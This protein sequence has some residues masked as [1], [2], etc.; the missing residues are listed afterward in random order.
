MI[1]CCA[2]RTC[3]I[4]SIVRL[5]HMSGHSGFPF[6]GNST[7]LN[8]RSAWIGNPSSFSV[9]RFLRLF[10]PLHITPIAH[11]THHGPISNRPNVWIPSRRTRHYL[12][13]T[14]FVCYPLRGSRIS[15]DSRSCDDIVQPLARSPQSGS[16]R[17]LFRS[18]Y[19]DSWRD[20]GIRCRMGF[21]GG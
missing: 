18:S 5:R 2:Q 21:R 11:Q 13:R 6:L 20:G 10:L 8:S 16:G 14:F 15:V 1:T 3:L 7:P 12:C 17:A 9:N 4:A 19:S